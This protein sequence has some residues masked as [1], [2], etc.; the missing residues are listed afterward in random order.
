M[1]IKINIQIEIE[2]KEHGKVDDIR[3][4]SYRTSPEEQK[5]RAADRLRRDQKI[6]F[7]VPRALLRG[8]LARYFH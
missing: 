8:Q 4:N 2:E 5:R 7:L 1:R 3:R 6:D